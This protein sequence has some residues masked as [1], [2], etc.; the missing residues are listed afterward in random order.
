M[1]IPTALWTSANR[2]KRANFKACVRAQ[3]NEL[4]ASRSDAEFSCQD[5]LRGVE[6]GW[7]FKSIKRGIKKVGKGVKKVGKVAYKYSG[8]QFVVKS[9]IA[10]A[11]LAAK[12][13]LLPFLLLLKAVR[14]LGRTLCKAP[15]EL[16]KLA[17]TQAGVDPVFIPAFCEAVR[18]NKWSLSSVRRMLPPA[19]KIALKLG[20]SGAF[21]P[22]VPALAI[23]KHIPG[24]GKFAGAELGSYH[25]DPRVNPT[26][27]YA[28]NLM[29]TLAIAD[30]LGMIQPMEA[31]AMGLGP[32]ARQAMQQ[33]LDG[34]IAEAQDVTAKRYI[35][36][37]VTAGLVAIVGVSLYSTLR[38]D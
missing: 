19:L 20:A 38:S 36:T 4:D 8:T 24:V 29:E 23:I 14:T 3:M 32:Q 30:R 10:L 13:A 33:H 17:A 26:L 18:I 22:I 6:L 16:L 35:S 25:S 15:P 27:R 1:A 28:V 9:N 31:H 37:A 11:K 7:G 21:P 34:A 5:E 12:L 2:A